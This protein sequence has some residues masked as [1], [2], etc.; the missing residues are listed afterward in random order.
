MFRFI[1]AAAILT[2]TPMISEAGGGGGKQRSGSVKVDNPYD[3]SV[4]TAIVTRAQYNRLSD[5]ISNNRIDEAEE[6]FL[7]FNP[8]AIASGSSLVYSNLRPGQYYAVGDDGFE[9]FASAEFTVT[10]GQET[11]VALALLE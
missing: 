6:L 10:A 3:I 4:P 8:Q 5:L 1:L 11:V 7:S 9:S 2:L